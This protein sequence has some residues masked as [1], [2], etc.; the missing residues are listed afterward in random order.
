MATRKELANPD[1]TA[2]RSAASRSSSS[3]ITS[4]FRI[5]VGNDIHR[6]AAGRKLILGGVRIPFEKGAGGHS[7]GDALAH[8]LG[9]A[10]LG[11]AALGDAAHVARG[12]EVVGHHPH[13]DAG[14]A[15]FAGR[16]IG[17]RL[18]A[19][20]TAVGEQV[21]ELAGA[22]AD[23]VRVDPAFAAAAMAR[24]RRIRYRRR[25]GGSRWSRPRAP[26]T[27]AGG[28]NRRHP[29][30]N[31]PRRRT[32]PGSRPERWPRSVRTRAG[33]P[34]RPPD[35]VLALNLPPSAHCTFMLSHCGSGTAVRPDAGSRR[36]GQAGSL[37]V[38]VVCSRAAGT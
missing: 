34:R 29:S 25:G 6:L 13:R 12:L 26:G 37:V 10:L 20:E 4:E 23:E 3:A 7:D 27:A 8:A 2:H 21:V 36:R 19:A 5:G 22:L 16:P 11:A 30:Q 35:S 18:A 14:A 15:A 1:K 33:V 9:D 32:P 24:G 17:D 31:R 28:G 38:L